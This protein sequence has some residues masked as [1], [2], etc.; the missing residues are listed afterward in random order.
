MAR[1]GVARLNAE[2]GAQRV[3]DALQ[4][5]E[6]ERVS[7]RRPVLLK[8]GSGHRD[9]DVSPFVGQRIEVAVPGA[10][11]LE[12]H[13][14]I[15]LAQVGAQRREQAAEEARAQNARFRRLRIGDGDRR[16]GSG[17]TVIR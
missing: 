16:V 15:A 12:D 10:R 3:D 11:Q 8:T 4:V 14:S 17:V 2:G 5:V 13:D 1:G 6:V 7:R 9:A